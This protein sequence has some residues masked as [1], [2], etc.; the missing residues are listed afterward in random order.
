MVTDQIE[1]TAKITR[2]KA[3]LACQRRALCVAISTLK[4]D[5]IGRIAM[6]EH[7]AMLRKVA[8]FE[9]DM[10]RAPELFAG[11][12]L[13]FMGENGWAPLIRA[14]CSAAPYLAGRRAA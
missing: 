2:A 6:G 5:R 1:A 14:I 3:L 8:S 11:Q 13:G 12:T 10:H 7:R 9:R 4:R